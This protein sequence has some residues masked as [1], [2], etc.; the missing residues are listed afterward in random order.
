[1]C[2]QPIGYL[3]LA[4]GLAG[5]AASVLLA[6]PTWRD[7]RGRQRSGRIKRLTRLV[8]TP[9]RDVLSQIAAEHEGQAGAFR[10]QDRRDLLRGIGLVMLAFLLPLMNKFALAVWPNWQ[11]C[12][13]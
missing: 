12:V 1:M 13:G 5:A 8:L 9:S 3:E 11:F 2:D 6:L 7:V 4:G 10:P